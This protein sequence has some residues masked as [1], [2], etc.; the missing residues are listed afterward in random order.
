M[1]SIV[2]SS[3][4]K[5]LIIVVVLMVIFVHTD[6]LALGV[7]DSV[8]FWLYHRF[9]IKRVF[10]FINGTKPKAIPLNLIIS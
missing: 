3:G 5:L 9:R 10:C 8:V 1:M 2:G 7:Y 6:Y 4:I